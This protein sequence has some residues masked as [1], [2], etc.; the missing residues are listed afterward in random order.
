VKGEKKN[1]EASVAGRLHNIAKASNM[2]YAEVLQYYGI[3]RFIYRMSVSRYSN[4]FVLKGA[5]LFMVWDIAGRRT[6]IDID[7]LAGTNN[8]VADVERIVREVCGLE[9][10]P[11]GLMF[12]AGTVRGQKIK[13]G[14]DYE[15]VRVKFRGMLERARIPM[16]IDFGFGDVVYP[17]SLMIDYPVILDSDKPRLLGYPPESV[18]SEKFESMVKLGLLNSRMKDFYDVWLMIRRFDFDGQTLAEAVHRTF[19]NRNTPLPSG[20]PLFADEIYDEKSDRQT[21]W[22]AFL[23][24]N[25]LK[26]VPAKLGD[27]ALEIESFLIEILEAL[28]EDREFAKTWKA[29]GPWA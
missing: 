25:E 7:V 27:I 29:P 19:Q 2:P 8:R 17:K 3:E 24:K 10:K 11:D 13:E 23:K 22:A 15:G 20:K 21:L 1:I 6:T 18:V 14:A 9:I 5:L 26:N 16:Q 28:F 4:R 12:N